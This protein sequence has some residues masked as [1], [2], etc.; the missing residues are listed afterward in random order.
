MT[1][2]EFI[3][4]VKQVNWA[5]IQTMIEKGDQFDLEDKKTNT[6]REASFPV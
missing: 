2:A 3:K 5:E 1:T 4:A 6:A